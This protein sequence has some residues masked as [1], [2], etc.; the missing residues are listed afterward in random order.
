[1]GIPDDESYFRTSY[2]PTGHA[3]GWRRV[4]VLALVVIVAILAVAGIV[5]G[6]VALS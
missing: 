4:L 6:I 2:V 3:T 1:M 5:M